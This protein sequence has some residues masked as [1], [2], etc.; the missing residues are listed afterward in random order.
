MDEK[1]IYQ[2]IL[3]FKRICN[4]VIDIINYSVLSIPQE[5]LENSEMANK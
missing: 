4:I 5:L 1:T 2:K 3:I